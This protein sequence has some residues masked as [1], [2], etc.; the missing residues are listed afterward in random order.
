MI[1]TENR[2]NDVDDDSYQRMSEGGA[3]LRGGRLEAEEST[4]LGCIQRTNYKVV[5][6]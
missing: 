2:A 4:V 5:E 6:E 1:P 3:G